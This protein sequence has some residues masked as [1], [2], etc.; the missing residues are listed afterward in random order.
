[1]IN[2]KNKGKRFEIECVHMLKD[3]GFTEARRTA[4]Y[5]GNSGDASDVVG[6]TGIHIECKFS[7]HFRIYDYMTQAVRDSSKSGNKPAVF[8]RS[9]NKETL[10]CMR[11]DD[12]MDLYKGWSK[13]NEKAE[14][15]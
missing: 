2:S 6:L 14:P 12:W 13:S 5:C 7:Q 3:K 11:F 15:K 8:F 10:V 4:Q 9:N 1:M